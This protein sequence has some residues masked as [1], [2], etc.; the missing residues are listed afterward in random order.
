M[1][2]SIS[3]DAIVEIDALAGKGRC[4]DIEMQSGDVIRIVAEKIVL[5]PA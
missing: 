5:P 2:P 3:V 1:G 4:L